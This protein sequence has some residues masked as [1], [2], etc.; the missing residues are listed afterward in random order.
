MEPPQCYTMSLY[1]ELALVVQSHI[2]SSAQ[3]VASGT[4]K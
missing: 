4:E 1:P 2:A 3:A